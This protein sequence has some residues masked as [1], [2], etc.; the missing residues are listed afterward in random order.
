MCMLMEFFTGAS[1]FKEL[2]LRQQDL[3][4][5]VQKMEY[6]RMEASEEIFK[7]GDV[8]DYFYILIH[9]RVQL[10]LPNSHISGV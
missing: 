1:C 9:G 4:K 6:K 10:F 5:V 2:D 7:I 8:G 3:Y